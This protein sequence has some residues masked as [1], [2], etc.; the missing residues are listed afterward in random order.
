MVV[1]SSSSNVVRKLK[2]ELERY[3]VQFSD[4]LSDDA[5]LGYLLSSVRYHD[6]NINTDIVPRLVGLS[7][8]G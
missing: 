6:T 7:G 1:I 4:D 5:D 3:K 2:L 8:L